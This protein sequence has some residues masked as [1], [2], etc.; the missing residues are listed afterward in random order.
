M[1]LHE[2][3]ETQF[4]KVVRK[5]ASSVFFP[6]F[7]AIICY[8]SWAFSLIFVGLGIATALFVILMVTQKNSIYAYPIFLLI[9]YMFPDFKKSYYF[10]GIY[11][12]ICVIAVLYNIFVYKVKLNKGGLFYPI[13]AT[14]F[15][16]AVGGIIYTTITYGFFKYIKDTLFILL[17]TISFGGGYLFLNNTVSTQE[18]NYKKYISITFCFLS[19]LLIAQM[20]TYYCNVEDVL[21]AIANKTLRIGWGNTNT[22]ATML[23][24]TIP[25]ILYLSTQYRYGAFLTIWAFLVYGAIWV[26]ESRGCILVSTP[27]LLFYVIYLIIKSKGLTRNLLI[28]IMAAL[29][30]AAA[31]ICIIFRDYL[32][33][34]FSKMLQKGLDDSGRIELYQ[35]AWELFKKHFIFGTGYF[36]KT[37]Q[38]KS[39]MYMFHSTPLQIMANLGVVGVIAFAYFYYHKYKILYKNIKSSFGMAIIMSILSL[40][41]YGLIDV[42][43]VVYFMAITTILLLIIA[44]RNSNEKLEGRE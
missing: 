20:V 38:T 8:I 6:L 13:L 31:A 21:K 35:E 10:T 14:F 5:F 3:A 42:S 9:F 16:A 26:T 30:I 41:L 22:L 28:A 34:V 24:V 36:Y 7:I 27:L 1:K 4:S 29:I 23:M 19:V 17:L 25:F 2:L 44:Q 11:L 15:A 37:D 33:Q 39:F 43:L 32:Y 12:G 18:V 40:E